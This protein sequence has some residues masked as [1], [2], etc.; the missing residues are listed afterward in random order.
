MKRTFLSAIGSTV[1]KSKLNVE[2]KSNQ[3]MVSRDDFGDFK[4]ASRR[5]RIQRYRRKD[6]VNSGQEFHD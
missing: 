3:A 6:A 1:A 4:L 2:Y 5:N